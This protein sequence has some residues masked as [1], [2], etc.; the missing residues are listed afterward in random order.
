METLRRLRM[1]IS[2]WTIEALPS[3]ID[4]EK[5]IQRDL[6]TDTVLHAFLMLS[7]ENGK[8]RYPIGGIEGVGHC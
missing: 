1:D 8:V 2:I 7:K 3:A 6:L 5:Q 4:F